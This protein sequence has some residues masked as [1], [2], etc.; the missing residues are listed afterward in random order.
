MWGIL[1]NSVAE[2]QN[3]PWVDGGDTKKQ[4]EIVGPVYLDGWQWHRMD[5][6]QAVHLKN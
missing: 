2:E 4:W 5:L 1:W 6:I 3:L